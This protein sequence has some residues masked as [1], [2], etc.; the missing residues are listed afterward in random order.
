MC[1]QRIVKALRMI[2]CKVRDHY[3][4]ADTLPVS[5]CSAMPVS[6]YMVESRIDRLHCH[7]GDQVLDSRSS[8]ASHRSLSERLQLTAGARTWN[9][10]PAMSGGLEVVAVCPIRA[11]W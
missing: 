11:R 6:S 10:R 3:G 4:Q 2:G 1:K 8:R 9:C 5:D 7:S